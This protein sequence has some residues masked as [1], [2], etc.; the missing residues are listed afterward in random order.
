MFGEK[1]KWRLNSTSL[2][3]PLMSWCLKSLRISLSE[4]RWCIEW[5]VALVFGYCCGLAL[6]ERS[7]WLGDYR[8]SINPIDCWHE[9]LTDVSLA[10]VGL[11]W[12][13]KGDR[14]ARW[15]QRE[16]ADACGYET[17][18]CPW[19]DE[20]YCLIFS[21]MAHVARKSVYVVVYP[22]EVGG[23]FGAVRIPFVMVQQFP[24]PLYPALYTPRFM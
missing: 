13:K 16:T 9:S 4:K 24:L 23:G 8:L 1:I 3:P 14:Q 17:R 5:N 2:I 20:K 12:G 18:V 19:M 7:F 11:W 21:R 22:C 15:W 10:T 6:R